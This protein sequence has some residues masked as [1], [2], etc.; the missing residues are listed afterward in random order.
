MNEIL[1]V[2]LTALFA[3]HVSD[4]ALGRAQVSDPLRAVVS[5][6]FALLVVVVAGVLGLSDVVD[7]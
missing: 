6:I 4:Y 1:E 3:F 2:I 7:L 5:A